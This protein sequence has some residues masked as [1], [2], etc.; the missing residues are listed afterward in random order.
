MSVSQARG[1]L[2][3]EQRDQRHFIVITVESGGL[4]PLSPLP[5]AGATNLVVPAAENSLWVDDGLPP[6]WEHL[7]YFLSSPDRYINPSPIG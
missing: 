2:G 3:N 1:R 4:L 7:L 5:G 6:E